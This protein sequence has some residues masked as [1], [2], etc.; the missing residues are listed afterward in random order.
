M[1]INRPKVEGGYMTVPT[2][3]GFDIQ[4][5]QDMVKKYTKN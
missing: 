3:P 2:G 4:L 1:W 5:D